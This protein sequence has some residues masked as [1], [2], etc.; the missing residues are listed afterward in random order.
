MNSKKYD[1]VNYP[2]R[3]VSD[4]KDLV[5]SST[6]MFP[7][8][9]AYLVKDRT[10]NAFVPITYGQ[11]KED[12]DALGTRM[13]DMGLKGQRIA[14][15]GE[16]SYPWILTYL[17]VA[18]G[19]GVIVPLDKNLPQNELLGLLERSG[20]KA[21]VYADKSRNAIE[22][23]FED[24]GGLDYI[25][26]MNN[27]DDTEGI[28]SLKKMIEEGKR[29]IMGGDRRYVTA[30]IDPDQM[31]TLLFTSGTT[32]MAKG[33]MLSHRNLVNNCIQLSAY[34]HI[35]DPGI[36]FSILPVH[37]VYAMTA[38]YL[39][40]F[41]Q[42][43]TIAICEGLRYIQKNMNEVHPN[44]MLG[45]PLVFE[46]LY[47]GMWKQ[48]K[49]RG[50]DEK[51]RSAIDL[52]K[53]LKLYKRPAV[54]K[55]MFASIHNSF[56]GDI[57]AF[58][59]GGAAADPYIIE[60]FEAMGFTM[61]QGYG[62]SECSPIIALN[63]DRY[64]KAASVGQPVMNAE[65]RVID[66]DEDGIGEIIVKSDSV[67]LG[68]YENKEATE[69][70]IQ[71]GWLHTG[72]L[73]YFDSDGFL[74]LTGRRK[75]VIVTKGGKNI[76]PEEL[77]E[78]LLQNDLI[79]EVVVHGVEDKRVGNVMVTAD[80]FP[81][82]DL[83]KETHGDMSSSDIYHFYKDLID[84]INAGFPPYK[85]IKRINIRTEA[86]A[87]TTTGKVKRYGNVSDTAESPEDYSHSLEYPQ[88]KEKDR[89]HAKKFAD[90]IRGSQ[91]EQIREREILPV[92]DIR[93]LL[94]ASVSK[95]GKN[96][97]FYSK[98]D[99]EMPYAAV[100]YDE[101][102]SDI[103]G[104]GTALINR[105]LA[106][107]NIGVCGPNSY[108]WAVSQL[109]VMSGVGAA[110]PLNH[111]LTA[112]ELEKRIQLAGVTCV[113]CGGNGAD[114]IRSIA[115][116]GGTAIDTLIFMD[117]PAAEGLPDGITVYDWEKLI[118]EGKDEMAQG[119]RQFLDAEITGHT[120]AMIQYTAGAEGEPRGVILS[121]SNICDNIMSQMAVQPLTPEDVLLA[122]MPF[123][124]TFQFVCGILDPLY[125]GASI[126]ICLGEQ[127]IQQGMREIR[128]TVIM[129]RP[130]QFHEQKKWAQENLEKKGTGLLKGLSGLNRLTKR[131]GLDVLKPAAAD[132]YRELGGRLRLIVSGGGITDPEDLEFFNNIGIQAVCGYG[133]T[134]AGP[135]ISVGQPGDQQK[136][137]GSAGRILPGL[138]V[139]IIGKD[140]SGTGEILIRG[141]SVIQGYYENPEA[142]AEAV[143]DGWL[144]TG[145]L[146]YVDS[147]RYLYVTGKKQTAI[148][149]KEGVRVY[150]EELEHLLMQIPYV[151]D[152]VIWDGPSEADEK[153]PVITA[154]VYVNQA[155][156]SRVIGDDHTDQQVLEQLWEDVDRIND[157]LPEYKRI[158]RVE[159]DRH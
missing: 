135:V 63:R 74:Y 139:K 6:S 128:P 60:E 7:D 36:V 125:R 39:T 19:V 86:F 70:A 142:T 148:E 131:I 100:S 152:A 57:K 12:L 11:V 27:D 136:H 52:S 92:T 119:D 78:V 122:V 32:G 143:T 41:Y 93:Q 105:D 114:K 109:T 81:N 29:L 72:D 21:I 117:A 103:N 123:D 80:I 116:A 155:E 111:D 14:V 84:Q 54:V 28:L 76:F 42:G 17:T 59:M 157:D 4:L 96:T 83:L 98:T 22:P 121:H 132:V 55:R 137:P 126:A 46:K 106:G 85:A 1:G 113:I 112:E 26:S 37:H 69:E 129:L 141:G 30:E 20:A 50:E 104:L 153:H 10:V 101:L 56:G 33:V 13:I 124:T 130:K 65:V 95:Y 87:K 67:M 88:A 31:S 156:V 108:R 149:V 75:T 102:M 77:E 107:K 38:D 115:A 71:D 158:R 118:S 64:R 47:K 138:D 154:S 79:Q 82:Y 133:L 127:Y 159:L 140:H 53:R 35:P 66:Q 45:V 150:P 91:D 8:Q 44:V 23:L 18:C 3:P 97:A 68:Y 48:A 62:M 49:H 51:L 146:G 9:T 58:V 90:A 145:D 5:N 151:R 16:N 94:E 89:R 15:I 40:T 34:F 2:T 134:E 61:V 120:T 24:R 110:V 144:H 99:E 25:I 147:E 73:G 43:K